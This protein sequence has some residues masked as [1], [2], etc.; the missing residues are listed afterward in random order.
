[1]EPIKA[2]QIVKNAHPECQVVQMGPPPGVLDEDCGT[3]EMLIGPSE[4]PI[5]GFSQGRA[6]YVYYR[7]SPAE[8]ETLK[9]GGFVEFAQYG[10]VVQPFSAT[11]WANPDA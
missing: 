3:A 11:I 1:M 5:K 4:G 6:N 9:N 10:Q 2:P 7:P 8:C